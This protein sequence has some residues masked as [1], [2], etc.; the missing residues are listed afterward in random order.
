M[1]F[2][3]FNLLKI[4]CGNSTQFNT[5]M[6][7]FEEAYNMVPTKEIHSNIN[8]EFK[9]ESYILRSTQ[10]NLFKDKNDVNDVNAGKMKQFIKINLDSKQYG[11]TYIKY[12][13]KLLD[14]EP[15]P[16]PKKI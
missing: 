2:K 4:E 8:N 3:C 10:S 14:Y 5:V 13:S 11:I 1:I 16:I 7:L 6:E 15:K 9:T 12:N